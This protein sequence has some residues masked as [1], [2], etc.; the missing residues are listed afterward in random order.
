[1]HEQNVAVRLERLERRVRRGNLLAASML[2]LGASLALIGTSV[3]TPDVSVVPELR[4]YKLTVLDSEG[5][6]RVQIAEDADDIPRNSRA[7]GLTIYDA[8]GDERGGIGTMANGAAVMA[9]DAPVGVGYK[10][11]DRAGM[12]VA[13]DGTAVITALSNEGSFAASLIAQG[14]QGRLELSRKDSAKGEISTRVLTFDSDSTKVE[15][16][17]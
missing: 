15:K 12:K 13:A 7:A 17:L 4:T 10:V 11:R 1:M 14:N 3:A 16:A 6:M 2:V 9:L 5:R 8:M